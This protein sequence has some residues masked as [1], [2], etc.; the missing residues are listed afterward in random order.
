M[1]DQAMCCRSGIP[2]AS[3]HEVYVSI[4]ANVSEMRQIR[5]IIRIRP[6]CRKRMQL[7]EWFSALFSPKISRMI[8]RVQPL[9]LRFSLSLVLELFLP[10]R[11]DSRDGFL[12]RSAWRF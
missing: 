6:N 3:E 7:K 12:F 8:L 2:A 4:S 5:L 10:E 11:R 9:V 1:K